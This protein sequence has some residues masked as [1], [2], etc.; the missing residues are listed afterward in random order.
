MS[1]SKILAVEDEADF[2]ILIRQRFRRQIRAEEFA[3]R[4]AHHGEEGLAVLAE[5]PDIELM[6]LDIN[7]PVMDGLTLL[8]ELRERQS[9][10]RA[11][12][13]S[14]Y[15]DMTN[16]RTAMNRGAFDFGTKPVDLNDLEIT[17]RKPLDDTSR[18]RE[19]DRRPPHAHGAR[20]N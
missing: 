13:V 7:M 3:L 6:L 14:A 4:F 19:I 9:E 12:I 10:V 17:I 16:L 2:E 15:G 11:I 20:T 1:P 5:E 8:A 18:I